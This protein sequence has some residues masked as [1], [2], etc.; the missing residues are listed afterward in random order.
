ME[1]RMVFNWTDLFIDINGQAFHYTRTGKGDKPVLVLLHGF[2][3]NGMCWM[4]VARELENTFD[5]IMPDAKGHGKSA[6]IQPG[7][8]VDGAADA[9]M[10]IEA[11][12]LD[13]PIV[14]GHSMGGI[15]ATELGARYPE[16]ISGL[17]LE[18]PAWIDPTPEDV[19]IRQ[20][21]FFE[22][23]LHLDPDTSQEDVIAQGRAG[24]RD[25]PET[26]FPAWAEAKLQLD[27]N[28]FDAVNVRKPWRDFVKEFRVPT[29][30]ITAEVERGAIIS[31]EVAKEAAH[32]STHL[33]T[34]NILG[35]GH[36]IRR[37][38]FPAYMEALQEFLQRF[39]D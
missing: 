8:K 15:T 26:E 28:V 30:L 16:L 4:P 38:N 25:W 14:G 11:L 17:V 10:F 33:F 22:W 6:R 7:E 21:P 2:S 36:N 31:P 23:L 35:A 9:A 39:S 1:N 13:K 3:D 27:K 5:V 34:V 24:N 32:L 20:N 18:D 12:G 37:E 19:P 29:L